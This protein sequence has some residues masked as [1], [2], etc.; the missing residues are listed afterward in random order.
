MTA[1]FREVL[2]YKGEKMGMAAEPLRPYLNSRDDI[3]LRSNCSA[4]WRGYIGNWEIKEEKLYLVELKFDFNEGDYLEMEDLFP[5]QTVVFAEWFSGEI[6]IPTGNML[7]YIHMGYGSI[8]EKDIYLEFKNGHLISEREENNRAKHRKYRE[9]QL[10]EK[11]KSS[12]K[13]GKKSWWKK[14]LGV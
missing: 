9:E 14:I 3:N 13:H 10:R 1:Q 11:Q 4:C 6:R 8:Y 2:F 12:V 5:G 7:E